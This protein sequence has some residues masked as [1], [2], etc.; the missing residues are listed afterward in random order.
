MVLK[1]VKIFEGKIRASEIFQFRKTFELIVWEAIN[2]FYAIVPKRL[3]FLQK[4]Y[5]SLVS[6]EINSTSMFLSII[7]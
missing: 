1:V 7:L 2:C 4:M 5:L 3:R 6:T